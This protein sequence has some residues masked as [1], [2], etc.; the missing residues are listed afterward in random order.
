MSSFSSFARVA[1]A[2]L[3]LLPAIALADPPARVGRLALIENGVDFR[4]D[5]DDEATAAALNWPISSGAMLETD[6]RGRAEIWIGSTAYRLGSNSRSEFVIVD[7]RQVSLQ[8][9]EGSLAVSILDR[10][11]ADDV[12]VHTPDGSIRFATPGRYRIDVFSDHSELSAQAGQA[13]L[14]DR[15]RITPVAAGQRASFESDGRVSIEGDSDLDG[16]DRWVAER[17]NATLASVTRRHV[18]PYMTGYQDLDA[19]GDWRPE[20]EYGSVW[21]P[22]GVGDDWAPYRFGRWA[23]VAPWGWTWIDQAPWGFTPF[24]YGRWAL[25]RGRWGWTPGHHSTRPVYAPA[26][27]GWLGN[28]GWSVSFGFGSAPAV[29]WFPLAPREV[30]V[31]RYQH[32]AGY[33][34]QINVTHVRDVSI[35]DRTVR[36]GGHEQFAHRATARAV[37]V[38][39]A[40]LLREGQSI[41]PTEVRRAERYDL[42]RAPLAGRAPSADWLAPPAAARVRPEGRQQ[43]AFQGRRGDDSGARMQSASPAREFD[44]ANRRGD[45]PL[46][47]REARDERPAMSPFGSV[48]EP[49]R[50]GRD[51]P[52]QERQERQGARDSAPPAFRPEAQ[53]QSP[54]SVQAIPQG[55]PQAVPAPRERDFRREMRDEPRQSLRASEAPALRPQESAPPA[56]RERDFRRET[57]DEPRQ[58]ARSV[59]A[60]AFRTPEA[61]SPVPAVRA[62]QPQAAPQPAL[63]SPSR[64]R[65]FR[66]EMRDEPRSAPRSSESPAF[67]TPE[68]PPPAPVI[69]APPQ[70]APQSAPPPRER[71]FRREMRAESRPVPRPSEAP[72]VRLPA[73]PAP[74]SAPQAQP[75]PQAVPAQQE[76]RGRDRGRGGERDRDRDERGR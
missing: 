35:I 54:A 56:F 75:Q 62:P 20:D 29:G 61:S 22:R 13:I 36:A 42:G 49:G 10:D 46:P 24:H 8:L 6:R 69:R 53:F 38:V 64:E 70:A 32:S 44:G 74:Q 15:G 41:T 39:P 60:P 33:V 4:A 11:Q 31:P 68:A 40:S 28:P 18:S 47:R 67:R 21:Y 59:E 23:W 72:A 51:V 57:R 17:E 9:D 76:S 37:T 5:R 73:P 14:D 25:I 19:Y 7:D 2:V 58:S 65:E 48:R 3:A 50:D 16:F 66:R 63:P 71:E 34:R 26:L 45:G 30:F 12:T 52:R 27:V 55:A 1:L 43:P